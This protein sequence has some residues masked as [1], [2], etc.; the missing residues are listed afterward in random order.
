MPDPIIHLTHLRP[1]TLLLPQLSFNMMGSEYTLQ[2]DC[3]K[4]A[5]VAE[6]EVLVQFKA[7]GWAGPGAPRSMQARV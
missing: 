4:G 3:M 6:E 2:S 7:T 5:G 1:L